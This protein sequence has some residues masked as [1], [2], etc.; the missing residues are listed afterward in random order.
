MGILSHYRQGKMSRSY[1]HTPIFKQPNDKDYKR[2]SNKIIRR[3]D[4]PSG[5]AFK[6]VMSSWNICDYAC[7]VSKVRHH[8]LG[9]L[10]D[11]RKAIKK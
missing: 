4:I 8:K 10:D 6:K 7:L 5:G 3:K 1:K 9:L 11:I 2:L